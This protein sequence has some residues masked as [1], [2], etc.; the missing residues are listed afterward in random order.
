M[1]KVNKL[2]VFLNEAGIGNPVRVNDVLREMYPQPE[3][4][5]SDHDYF[6]YAGRIENFLN[7]LQNA[8]LIK[9]RKDGFFRVKMQGKYFLLDDCNII[10]SITYEGSKSIEPVREQPTY[11]ATFNGPFAGN[12][13]Q[14]E[15]TGLSQVANEE[16][17]DSKEL[18]KKLLA[19]FPKTVW[20]RHWGF[21]V[22]I[23]AILASILIAWLS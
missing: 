19:D 13:N 11:S 4:F 7:E 8:N 14:G 9:Y 23:L 5:T 18:T 15:S 12:F 21:I 3:N 1:E 17:Q 6:T 20:Y 22:A 16:N 2:L 10:A